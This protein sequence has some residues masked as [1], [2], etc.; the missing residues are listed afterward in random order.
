MA[1]TTNGPPILHTLI[2][3]M[4]HDIGMAGEYTKWKNTKAREFTKMKEDV[5]RLKAKNQE[6]EKDKR[7]LHKKL[8]L[9][10]EELTQTRKRLVNSWKEYTAIEKKLE[11]VQEDLLATQV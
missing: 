11:Q 6:L 9:T 8:N 7:R 1:N 3:F 5:G 4:K 2:E 10:C